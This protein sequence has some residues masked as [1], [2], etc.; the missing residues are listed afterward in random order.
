MWGSRQE[1]RCSGG[2]GYA[3]PASSGWSTPAPPPG[4]ATPTPSSASQHLSQIGAQSP[5]VLVGSQIGGQWQPAI[6]IGSRETSGGVCAP[7]VLKRNETPRMIPRHAS[8][9][10]EP[11]NAT[12]SH[13]PQPMAQSPRQVVQVQRSISPAPPGWTPQSTIT[14]GAYAYRHVSPPPLARQ[15]SPAPPPAGRALSPSPLSPTPLVSGR[16]S[17]RSP[18]RGSPRINLDTPASGSRSSIRGQNGAPLYAMQVRPTMSY[19]MPVESNRS[20][21]TYFKS[22]QPGALIESSSEDKQQ[23]PVSRTTTVTPIPGASAPFSAQAVGE[24]GKA[25]DSPTA[26]EMQAHRFQ[27]SGIAADV[28]QKP[29]QMVSGN[30]AVTSGTS[31]PLLSSDP[32]QQSVTTRTSPSNVLSNSSGG[33]FVQL[34]AI[35]D[36]GD[37]LLISSRRHFD[38]LDTDH[39]GLLGPEQLVKLMALMNESNGLTVRVD[40]EAWI[41]LFKKYGLHNDGKD[42]LGFDEVFALYSYTL[43]VLRD[44]YA[45]KEHLR[46]MKIVQRGC[47]RL[48]DHY[49]DFEFMGKGAFGKIYRCA[50]RLSKERRICKQ[51]RKDRTA[52]PIDQ[53]RVE[54]GMLLQLDH[55]HV[56]RIYDYIEDFNNFYIICEPCD[57]GELM[58][59]IQESYMKGRRVDEAWVAEVMRQLLSAVLYCHGRKPKGILHRD[60]KPDSILLSSRGDASGVDSPM[61]KVVIVDFGLAELFMHRG[62]DPSGHFRSS[63][64]IF[65]QN[66]VPVGNFEFTAPEVWVRS[67][68]PKCDV[69]SCGCILFMLLTGRFPFGHRL[70]TNQL[71]QLVM[72]QEPDWTSFRHASTGALSLCRRMLT[73]DDQSRP[74]AQECLRHPW[75]AQ[76]LTGG[77]IRQL[78]LETLSALVQFHAQSKFHQVVMNLVASELSVGQLMRVE[79]TFKMLDGDEDGEITHEDLSTGLSNLGVS[80]PNIEKAIRALDMENTGTLC[81]APFVAGCVDLVDDKLDHMLW[82]IFTMIDE[83]HSGEI[84]TIELEHFL[85][86][87]CDEAGMSNPLSA[88]SSAGDVERYL[89]SILDPELTA[90]EIV[91]RIA[92]GHE[93]VTFEVLKSFVIAGACAGTEA[94]RAPRVQA[95]HQYAPETTVPEVIG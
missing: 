22:A 18:P 64:R 59:A 17:V 95:H 91:A 45:P 46:R 42:A 79:E 20:A 58:E 10:K 27:S 78:R 14:P 69:W 57:G 24:R 54:L 77:D 82:K 31:L 70:T 62:P 92:K 30:M 25:I 93:V 67:F 48:K 72:S 68:G 73:K 4:R 23:Q 50:D 84:S 15:L 41:G 94:V 53:C 76:D 65:E 55:P 12:I 9:A 2:S 89:K 43:R 66:N 38:S 28:R 81:F 86:T 3:T 11:P 1:R 83:D 85:R 88:A 29:N 52:V 75:L 36:L 37:A 47:L 6:S 26:R 74:S 33:P 39:D 16:V 40:E 35:L 61:P 90:S 49:E 44:K 80:G 7:Q 71:A 13:G 60:L 34:S 32:S 5:R 63:K 21:V 8:N 87:A 19:A 56:H 51:I